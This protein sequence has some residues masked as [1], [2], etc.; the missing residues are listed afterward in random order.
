MALALREQENPARPDAI[1]EYLRDRLG[2]RVR[3]RFKRG[4]RK[5]AL[6]SRRRCTRSF[7]CL[8]RMLNIAVRKNYSQRTPVWGWNFRSPWR[9]CFDRTTSRGRNRRG[10]N[11]EYLRNVVQII[12]ETGLRAYKE[13]APMRRDQADLSSAVVWI[14]DSKTPNGFA[15]VPSLLWQLKLFGAKWQSHRRAHSSLGGQLKSG[16]QSRGSLHWPV[17]PV[18]GHFVGRFCRR[19][20]SPGARDPYG[21]P[22]RPLGKRLQFHAVHRFLARSFVKTIRAFPVR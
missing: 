21:N 16:L 12:T 8:G 9:D 5:R 18:G 22:S 13:L 19:P 10:L 2:Q 17:L 7:G 6:S 20:S 11:P 1:E 15:E 4:Y 14:P 3:V